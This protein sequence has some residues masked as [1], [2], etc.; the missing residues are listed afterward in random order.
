MPPPPVPHRRPRT[1]QDH[2]G[3]RRRA[4]SH[5]GQPAQ[6]HVALA[7]H[8]R[9]A[10]PAA[11]RLHGLALPALRLAA[12]PAAPDR[13]EVGQARLQGR[14][15]RQR[16]SQRGQPR[17]LSTPCCAL[18]PSP[19]RSLLL[20]WPRLAA[21][22]PR[23]AKSGPS[24]ALAARGPHAQ[25][26]KDARR[27]ALW[28]DLVGRR[29]VGQ[30]AAQQPGGAG[31]GRGGRQPPQ[32]RRGHE[33]RRALRGGR[34]RAGGVPVAPGRR[35]LR[36]GHLGSQGA[37]GRRATP[38]SSTR[39]PSACSTARSGTSR[40]SHPA[41]PRPRP[42]STRC[43]STAPAR[44]R[45]PPSRSASPPR[46]S[47]AGAFPPC[48]RSHTGTGC[49]CS[50]R[51]PPTRTW[52]LSARSRC[53]SRRRALCAISVIYPHVSPCLAYLP[54]RSP[55]A[56][57]R[58]WRTTTRTLEAEYVFWSSNQRSRGHV[59]R[60]IHCAPVLTLCSEYSDVFMT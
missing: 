58:P 9:R 23:L 10:A 59:L 39:S 15:Q 22:W 25:L 51:T 1:R 3:P 33:Q 32:P 26:P 43:C 31:P 4:G 54:R 27:A 16:R 46:C 5:R 38:P 49:R 41:R 52:R 50:R 35:D 40:P 6:R 11:G 2:R 21:P 55:S 53:S 36:R 7:R 30:R 24:P 8:H 47:R 12:A 45:W 48:S 20:H 13:Q 28:R 57:A 17:G 42:A 60:C 29:L 34:K 14:H 19:G 18:L 44:A 56:R 37:D